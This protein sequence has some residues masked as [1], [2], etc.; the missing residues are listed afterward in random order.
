MAMLRGMGWK[1]SDGKSGKYVA[2]ANAVFMHLLVYFSRF[3]LSVY[4]M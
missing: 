2:H 1:D 4:M 3:Y